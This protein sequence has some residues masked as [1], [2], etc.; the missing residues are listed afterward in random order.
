M[1]TL[2]QIFDGPRRSCA[3]REKYKPTTAEHIPANIQWK[4]HAWDT[5]IH[6]HRTNSVSIGNSIDF[7]FKFACDVFSLRW[8]PVKIHEQDNTHTH[9]IRHEHNSKL[10]CYDIYIDELCIPPNCWAY[11]H[12]LKILHW[13][14]HEEIIQNEPAL[15]IVKNNAQSWVNR[16]RVILYCTYRLQIY[17]GKKYLGLLK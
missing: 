3:S 17:L 2:L 4:I 10:A 14:R 1:H 15:N 5:Q 6:T 8:S 9:T 13:T 7:E 12:I 16:I 11:V